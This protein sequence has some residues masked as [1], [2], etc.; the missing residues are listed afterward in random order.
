MVGEGEKV[1]CGAEALEERVDLLTVGEG[2]RGGV[3]FE[4]EGAV[5]DFEG[6]D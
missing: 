3:D 1:V 2:S 5:G 6:A 4:V